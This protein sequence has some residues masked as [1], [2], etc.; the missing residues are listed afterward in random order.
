MEM[1]K[2]SSKKE[3]IFFRPLHNGDL[4]LLSVEILSL[5]FICTIMAIMRRRP[6]ALVILA[7]L[8]FL[9]PI[10]NVVLN[11]IISE[12]DILEYF[13]MAMSP[14][15][16]AAN[17][18]IVVAPLVAG[19]AIYACKKWSFYVYMFA[20]TTLFV[21]SYA[22]YLSKSESI[23]LFPVLFVY[24]VNIFVVSYFLIPAVRNI[25]FD[26]RLRW[27][28]IQA[29]YKCQFKCV[30]KMPKQDSGYS[31]RIENISE[32]GLFVKSDEWPQDHAEID[33]V[34]PFDQGLVAHFKGQVILHKR[35]DADG[36]GVK[37]IHNKETRRFAKNIIAD[38]E[39][40]GM[41][42]SAIDGRPEDSFTFWVRTLVTTGKGL[43]PNKEKTSQ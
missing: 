12:K 2:I 25:Y 34:L 39:E 16:L 42:I 1:N 13:V 38:L 40:Q 31:G 21:F 6:W 4:D 10:G 14:E 24:V 43:L 37:F 3:N 5:H 20:I 41:R 36:F 18:I 17:W 27:W 8:H 29:R 22:G 23:G 11:A 26:R 32:N 7:I 9:A 35:A 28:E 15:Y 33:I 19:A 30:W